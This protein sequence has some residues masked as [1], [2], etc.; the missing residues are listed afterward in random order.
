MTYQGPYTIISVRSNN[1]YTVRINSKDRTYHVNLLKKYFTRK[2][3]TENSA[4]NAIICAAFIDSTQEEEIP[5]QFLETKQ[6]EC[7]SDVI[8][9]PELTTDQQ[10]EI[11]QLVQEF[12]ATLSD[13]PGKT[14]IIQH[15]IE[16]T[17][18][19][20]VRTKQY[21]I[22]YHAEEKIEHEIENMLAHDIIRPSN[23]PY[24]SPMTIVTKKSKEIRLCIDFRKI[25]TITVFDCQPI[26]T[27]EELLNKLAKAKFFTKLDLTKGY[28]QIPIY[29]AHKKYTAFQTHKGLME[30]NYMPFGLSTASSTFAR[31]MQKALCKLKCVVSY[32]DDVLIYSNTWQEHMSHIRQTLNALREANF[33]VRPTKTQIGFRTIDFLGH[34]ISEGHIRPDKDK[35]EKIAQIKPPKTKKDTRRILGLLNY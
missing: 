21:P 9:A 14:H 13:V 29:E 31:G 22:P 35:T 12:T 11:K 3:E 34:T 23:S 1:N 2:V 24:C 17:S 6:Q 15:H 7:H 28:W 32:F 4:M 10:S 18:D 30:F 8:I 26:P 27:L 25:N 33:T 5:I 20:P 16:L 19:T